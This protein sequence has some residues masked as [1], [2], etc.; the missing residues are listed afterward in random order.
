MRLCLMIEGQEDVTWDQWCALAEACENSALE[1]LFRSDHYLS[2]SGRR[3]LGSLDAWTTLAGLAARTQRIRLGTLVSPVTFR[4][5]SVLAKSVAT[6]DHISGGRA[7]L[8]IGAGWN[9]AEHTAYGFP[10]PDAGVRLE[11]LA[12]QIEIVHRQWSDLPFEFTGKHYALD[13]L[14]ALPKPLQEPH[15]NLIVGGGANPRSASLAARWADEYN[16]IYQS[17]AACSDRRERVAAA[18]QAEGRDPATLV[19]SLMTGCIVGANRRE[20]E[21]RAR[22]VMELSDER[23]PVGDWIDARREEWV[24]G[25]VSEV[26]DHLGRL[27]DAGVERVML[28]HLAHDDVDMV[29]LIGTEVDRQLPDY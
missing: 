10:F 6:V 22:R 21:N 2:V 14:N 11:M 8:G 9:V 24:I 13:D 27:R 4:H 15:P 3:D 1:G 18:W 16:V 29:A 19:F 12:E 7:E 26:V 25:T 23:G 20:L 28:Q 5:P 17:P